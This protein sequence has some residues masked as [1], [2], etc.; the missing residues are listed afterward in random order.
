MIVS[1]TGR[2]F[3]QVRPVCWGSLIF[4]N[5]QVPRKAEL[6]FKLME[7]SILYVQCMTRHLS[8]TSHLSLCSVKVLSSYCR[9]QKSLQMLFRTKAFAVCRLWREGAWWE[10]LWNSSSLLASSTSTSAARKRPINCRIW[11]LRWGGSMLRQGSVCLCWGN[12][13]PSSWWW[14]LL[15]SLLGTEVLV[16]PWNTHYS[17]H[18]CVPS[19]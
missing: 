10:S 5:S 17:K 1:V 13:A 15:A 11:C 4:S 2:V 16:L 3:I 8:A 9:L 14:S 18:L 6:F 7:R 12:R 19:N